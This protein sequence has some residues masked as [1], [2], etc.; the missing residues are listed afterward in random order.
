MALNKKSKKILVLATGVLVIGS[1]LYLYYGRDTKNYTTASPETKGPSSAIPQST[2]KGLSTNTSEAG[3]SADSSDMA[4]ATSP[5]EKPSG[6]FISN[7]R[8]SLGGDN[9]SNQINS[10]CISTVGATCT[11]TMTNGNI[12]VSLPKQTTDS[13]GATYWTWRLQ[14]FGITEGTWKVTATATIGG[15]KSSATDPTDLVVS[16]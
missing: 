2:D 5:P 8:P 15:L 10:S 13:G 4:T 3:A 12:S 16:K 6:V 9:L 7:H 1:L 11:I 14:D